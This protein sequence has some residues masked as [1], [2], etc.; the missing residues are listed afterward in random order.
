VDEGDE[1][2]TGKKCFLNLND[3]MQKGCYDG[4]YC[5]HHLLTPHSTLVAAPPQTRILFHLSITLYS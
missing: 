5:S 3:Y 1:R 2:A 4:I